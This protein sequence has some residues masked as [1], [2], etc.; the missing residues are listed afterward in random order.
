MFDDIKPLDEKWERRKRQLI[1]GV[2]IFLAVCGYLYYE[3]KNF[4][5]ER[6]VSHFMEALERQDYQE[7][8]RLWQPSQYYTFKNF[9][10]DWG[11][12][13]VEGVINDF[14]ITNSRSRGSGVVVD[15]RVNGQKQIRLWVEKS[16]R[17]LSFPP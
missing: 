2:P 9:S 17:S 3:F 16:T 8:Y 15:V 4:R 10:E 6:A 11:P 12:D 14:D 1:I 13:G 7:A 5:E